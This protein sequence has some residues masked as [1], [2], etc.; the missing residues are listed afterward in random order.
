MEAVH[1]FETPVK[2]Q[3]TRRHISENSSLLFQDVLYRKISHLG[4]KIYA[5]MEEAFCVDEFC[6][7]EL[8]N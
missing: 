2:Y 6:V 8:I 7:T 3:T 4:E 5:E 1:S